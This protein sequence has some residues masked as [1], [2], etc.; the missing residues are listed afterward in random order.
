MKGYPDVR[1]ITLRSTW[2]TNEPWCSVCA[3]SCQRSSSPTDRHDGRD[4]EDRPEDLPRL[5]EPSRHAKRTWDALHRPPH[6][7]KRIPPFRILYFFFRAMFHTLT[8]TTVRSGNYAAYRGWLAKRI[9]PIRT[10]ISAIR[11]R[12]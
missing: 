12:L 3:S 4:G 8:G 11:P 10:S 9:L 2:D 5:T 1:V 6:Q 7:T